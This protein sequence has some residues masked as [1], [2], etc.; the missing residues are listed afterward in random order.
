MKLKNV[1]TTGSDL[2]KGRVGFGH[3]I[4]IW[5][6]G[7][8]FAAKAGQKGRICTFFP[9]PAI[10]IEV[11][12]SIEIEVVFVVSADKMSTKLLLRRTNHLVQK[13]KE[14]KREGKKKK[15]KN[16]SFFS[17]VEKAIVLSHTIFI[18]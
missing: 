18:A 7:V 3:E 12:I 14:K 6:F 16:F 5:T 15:M 10:T 13:R 17:V 4:R 8:G 1:Q 2:V 11:H 9:V